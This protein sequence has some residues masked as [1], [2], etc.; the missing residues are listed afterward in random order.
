MGT[1]GRTR[2][3]LTEKGGQ[4]ALSTSDILWTVEGVVGWG[5]SGQSPFCGQ[6]L[7][8]LKYGARKVGG[9][10]PDAFH[11]GEREG[12]GRDFE[13]AGDDCL[14]QFFN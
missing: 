12:L 9:G 6:F 13:A 2:K 10:R 3:K 8:H 11:L 14:Q 4:T 7:R 1:S 5:Q